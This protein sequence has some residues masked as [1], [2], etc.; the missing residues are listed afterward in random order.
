MTNKQAILKTQRHDPFLEQI[1]IDFSELVREGCISTEVIKLNQS[2]FNQQWMLF[3]KA[4]NKV[5]QEPQNCDIKLFDD[6]TFSTIKDS[7]KT[8]TACRTVVLANICDNIP[9]KGKP[10]LERN[11]TGDGGDNPYS[12]LWKLFLFGKDSH[13][14]TV[15]R[16]L[17]DIKKHFCGML[18]FDN[19]FDAAK[20]VE[21]FHNWLLESFPT[22]DNNNSPSQIELYSKNFIEDFVSHSRAGEDLYS[23][24]LDFLN[25]TPT[26]PSD[27]R[28]KLYSLV[29]PL[30]DTIDVSK[31][32]CAY[33][34]GAIT[35]PPQATVELGKEKSVSDL[36]IIAMP[37]GAVAKQFNSFIKKYNENYLTQL[38]D[39]LG[40]TE[41]LMD[42]LSFSEQ[43]AVG[44]TNADRQS[45]GQIDPSRQ[46]EKESKI[47]A[48]ITSFLEK[49]DKFPMS[50]NTRSCALKEDLVS[51]KGRVKY[52]ERTHGNHQPSNLTRAIREKG[53]DFSGCYIKKTGD[54]IEISLENKRKKKRNFSK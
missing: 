16:Y 51:N 10:Y 46:G 28:A 26:L 35:E 41:L 48:S 19:V 2:I 4:Y 25:E 40:K 29:R 9:P 20:K 53:F 32:M 15:E 17:Y 33:A 38:T 14:A 49:L 12:Q 45:N 5:G 42:T 8:R 18:T 23:G 24:I 43:L 13:N 22:F 31:K 30:D 7:G 11:N 1:A 34:L 39:W 21:R 36:G 44:A 47:G 37:L 50:K 6:F 3:L 54:F 52:R 27:L